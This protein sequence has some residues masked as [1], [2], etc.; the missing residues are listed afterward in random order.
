[1]LIYAGVPFLVHLLTK[2][3]QLRFTL[4]IHLLGSS[5]LS[6]L[7]PVRNEIQS[8]CNASYQDQML[9]FVRCSNLPLTFSTQNLSSLKKLGQ[10]IYNISYLC[11]YRF[12]T[13]SPRNVS[14]HGLPSMISVLHYCQKRS[15]SI[16]KKTTTA[17]CKCEI[18]Y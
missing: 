7:P 3:H 6:V 13:V 16:N 14:F 11:Y 5:T 8:R 9:R 4:K 17:N 18:C 2:R 10:G 1:M 15:E 12:N